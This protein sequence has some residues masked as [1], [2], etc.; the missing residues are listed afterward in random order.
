MQMDAIMGAVNAIQEM[1]LHTVR[2]TMCVFPA[3]PRAWQKAASFKQMR[4]EG[5]FLVSAEMKEGRIIEVEI[6]SEK[7]A[8][9]KLANNI[10]PEIVVH[11]G[12]KEER[13][14][15]RLLTVQ[16]E[17]GETITIHG[18]AVT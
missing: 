4:A 15:A 7:G 9:L 1:L 8:E 12:G 2:G 18:A 6:F 17:P 3:T 10:A 16:T 11:R 14:S 13:T 5:A